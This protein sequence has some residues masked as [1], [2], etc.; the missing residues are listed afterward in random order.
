MNDYIEA[1]GGNSPGIDKNA[2]VHAEGSV[3]ICT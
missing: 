1:L 2:G 3:L